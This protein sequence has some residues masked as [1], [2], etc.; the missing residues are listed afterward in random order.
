MGATA[1]QKT[2]GDVGYRTIFSNMGAVKTPGAV[3]A[4][5]KNIAITPLSEKDKQTKAEELYGGISEEEDEFPEQIEHIED[6]ILPSGQGDDWSATVLRLKGIS[7]LIVIFYMT[8]S[9]GHTGP[10]VRK[11]WQVEQLM[12]RLGIPT[13]IIGYMNMT[14]QQM[15]ETGWP[16]ANELSRVMP[17]GIE[18]SCTNGGRLIDYG[19]ATSRILSIVELVPVFNTPFGTHLGM[20]LAI[21]RNARAVN[22]WQLVRPKEIPTENFAKK[23]E[24]YMSWNEAKDYVE[25]YN[26]GKTRETM[27]MIKDDPFIQEHGNEE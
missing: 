15:W 14:M 9:V 5:K 16:Q 21:E 6:E 13:V 24:V 17:R 1:V 3:W 19:W 23:K 25:S 2:F 7:I 8:S 11:L 26:L 4:I 27:D 10:N 18:A 20:M 12:K 22:A